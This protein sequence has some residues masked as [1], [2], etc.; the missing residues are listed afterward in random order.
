MN[1]RFVV[2]T[3]AWF[4]GG[5]DLTPVLRAAAAGRCRYDHVPRR[6]EQACDAHASVAP[7]DKYKRWCDEYFYLKHRKGDARDRRH[8]LRLRRQRRPGCRLRLHA[9][10]RQ[11]V[12]AHFPELVPNFT[13]PSAAER[14][15]QLCAAAAMWSSTCSTIAA[16]FSGSARRQRR[17]DPVLAATGGEMAV[18]DLSSMARVLALRATTRRIMAFAPGDVVFLKSGGS[19]MT[20]TAVG[21]TASTAHRWR[22]EGR[23]VPRASRASRDDRV[24]SGR[25]RRG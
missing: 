23:I 24:R 21:R 9:G 2:T 19:P 6:D 20:V 18:I 25:R 3:K 10:R 13:T 12:P 5:A 1:T 15:E 8:F 7:Y 4:G 11:R 16:L 17:V 14:E 22:G